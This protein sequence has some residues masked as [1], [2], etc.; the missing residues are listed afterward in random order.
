MYPK[1]LLLSTTLLA[2]ASSAAADPVRILLYTGTGS[3]VEQ[4]RDEFVRRHGNGLI[5]L[6]TPTAD[7]TA[8][9][10]DRAS[11]AVLIHLDEAISLR[12]E[13]ALRRLVGRGTPVIV[14][15]QAF[16]P[17]QWTWK[18]DAQRAAVVEQYWEAGGIENAVNLLAYL[19]KA[20]GGTANVPVAPPAPQ[21]DHGIYHPRAASPF[22][23]LREYLA[24]YRAQRI[25]PDTA[26]LVG[27]TFY[28]SSIR[29]HDL[30]HIRA[31][32]AELERNALG[33]VPVFGWPFNTIEPLLTV[34]GVSPLRLL[35]AMNLSIIRPADSVLLER[36]GIHALNLQASG[37]SYAEW[38][39]SL[40]G[41][42][43]DS[44]PHQV[45]T[46]ERAA[47][48]EPI[49]IAT[50]E[51]QAGSQARVTTP[52]PERVSMAVRRAKRWL[53]LQDLPNARKRIVFVYY[54]NP[55]GKGNLGASYLQ[56]L[57]S[58]VTMLR[59]LEQ[60]GYDT[61]PRLPDTKELTDVLERRGRNVEA[62]A[63]GELQ[64]MAESA[65]MTLFS[66][67]DY[68][69]LFSTLPEPFK[70]MVTKE[71][72]PPEKAEL[73][74]I[75]RNGK[76]YFLIPGAT[77]GNVLLSVQPLRSTAER[78]VST[79]HDTTIPVPHSYI[80]AYLYYRHVFKADAIVHIGRHGTLEW[81]PGKQVMQS[82]SDHSEVLLD[83]V[84]N[85]YLYIMDGDGEALQAMRRS[86]GVM[87]S[88]LTPLLVRGGTQEEIRPLD[89][90]LQ[91]WAATRDT[92]PELAAEYRQQAIAAAR[93][94]QLDRQLGLDL[95]G[96]WPAVGERL[97]AWV[98]EVQ[99]TPIPAGIHAL[100]ELPPAELQREA[101]QAF[102]RYGFNEAELER[103]EHE[104]RGWAD[105]IFESRAPA[106]S[107][108]YSAALE[109]RIEAHWR[110]AHT[111]LGN[112]RISPRREVD[113]LPQVLSGRYLPAS[114]LGDPLR[115][116]A[117]LATGRKQ[118]GFDPTLIP[119]KAAWAVGRKMADETIARY[120]AEH[121]GQFPTK[122]S[123]MLWYGETD[124]HQGAMESMALQLMGVEVRWN[125]R[126]QPDELVLVP[127]SA[128]THP[129]VDVV[130]NI[131][132]IYRDGFGDKVLL[133]DRAARLVSAAGDN[134]IS[135]H[136]REVAD[137]L[138]AGGVASDVAERV[139]RARVFGN[140]PGA[141]SIGVDRLVAQ[142]RDVDDPGTLANL[143]L[144][145]MNA[146]FSQESWGEEAPQALATHLKGNQAVLFSRSSNLYGA[147]DNDDTF[148][149]AGGMHFASKFVNG[150]AAPAF[151]INNLRKD[152]SEKTVDLK[153]WLATE[154]NQRNWNPT[155][156]RHMQTSG[157][158]GARE[159]NAGVEHL[160][161]FQATAAE[162]MDGTF[163][164]NTFD[165]YVA[166]KHGLQLDEFFERE[167]PH[168]RQGIL[169]RLLEVDRQ[170]SYT[171][172]DADR[173][174]LM[175]DYVRS[176]ARHGVACSANI[177]GNMRLQRF[178]A[179]NAPLV[180]GLGQIDVQQFARRMA[181]AT[182]A[183]QP[184]PPAADA[185]AM[186]APPSRAP[187]VSG[188][189]MQE[190]ITRIDNAS[191]PAPRFDWV[192]GAL[193]LAVI[194][195]GTAWEA[196]RN[197]EVI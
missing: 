151:Y 16:V 27:L 187:T 73:S 117:G 9:Q 77:Y 163:W 119:T 15:P 22:V 39:A 67:D 156:I 197:Y 37:Q 191:Q 192:V 104:L 76:D 147:L 159:M 141:Y 18:P 1:A 3:V 136:D 172:S 53:A 88:H 35:L 195:A 10:V 109:D 25:V 59:R 169:A 64:A 113:A 148:S 33:A 108:E 130:F 48:A 166:D 70:A 107:G 145:N 6:D 38:S 11:V 125:A 194:A 181:R 196:G 168:A 42:M 72:G 121:G 79:T 95:A 184:Q 140:K 34:D 66:V 4:A 173:E 20:G 182:T 101:L 36:L 114:P 47:T 98:G 61:G 152:G 60:E 63:P 157:Y 183:L 112:L 94:L 186:P 116:P 178:V 86:A 188:F 12:L 165:V 158:A 174:R 146:A 92:Q 131:S 57:P 120:R 93:T 180:Q 150:G 110:D 65:G 126:N 154:L 82:G 123:M 162:Q 13:P 89:R 21:L 40:R 17:R 31:V 176:V 153:T 51:T 128:M 14:T 167:N 171:F 78:A 144:H 190:T 138:V 142:S 175:A 193:L 137:A 58:M 106:V 149:Y 100:G 135:R 28:S 85:P 23:S 139:A 32:I 129:R 56:I 87:M 164:Q 118:Y 2:I 46:P 30:A 185:S 45:A 52:I 41:L 29:Q 160:Y 127:D 43:P 134:V 71:Y 122:V 62:W 90:A 75:R 81:L 91:E 50:T 105:A 7:M 24:W 44:V 170:G 54:N 49:L 97:S 19:Y 55:P 155:W 133:L 124:R 8:D 111:W 26:P 102:L 5:E 96:P 115:T 80:A 161:G 103:V 69:R 83:D 179:A 84:P 189:V 99:D 177:C 74:R 143:Y 132:G 68:K